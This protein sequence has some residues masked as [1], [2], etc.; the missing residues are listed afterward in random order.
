MSITVTAGRPRARLILFSL[1]IFDDKILVLLTVHNDGERSSRGREE[2]LRWNG[3]GMLGDWG[4]VG[5]CE[6][7]SAVSSCSTIG[8]GGD[9]T[10]P[11]PGITKA[12]SSGDRT[13]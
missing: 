2:N 4:G 8:E 10:I 6:W 12:P 9:T 3:N 7:T 13:T 11:S 5:L 1:I